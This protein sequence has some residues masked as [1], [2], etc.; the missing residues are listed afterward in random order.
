[1]T[2]AEETRLIEAGT[3]AKN[4]AEGEHVE[5]QF[6]DYDDFLSCV[7][8]GRIKPR[9]GWPQPCRGQVRVALRADAQ[10]AG[11]K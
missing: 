3:R 11:D 5:F 4:A 7:R 1:M 6:K 9:A 10:K 8:C 2:D